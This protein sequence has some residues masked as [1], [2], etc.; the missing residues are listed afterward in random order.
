MSYT[1][2]GPRGAS[3]VILLHG[4]PYS[5]D[6]F[7][8]AAARLVQ[9]GHRVIVPELRGHGGTRFLSAATIRNGQQSALASDVVA[10]MDAL[11]VQSAV[12]G[13]CDWGARTA[14]IVAACGWNDVRRSSR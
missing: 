6:C 10:L 8:E 3:A 9:A 13:G 2:L 12:L 1:D 11:G 7:A 5:I 14:C 4:W